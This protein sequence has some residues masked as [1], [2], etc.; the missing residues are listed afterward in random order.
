[1]AKTLVRSDI[2]SG[3]ICCKGLEVI[4]DGGIF[5]FDRFICGKLIVWKKEPKRKGKLT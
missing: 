5:Y 3:A 2:C 4:Y 1:M